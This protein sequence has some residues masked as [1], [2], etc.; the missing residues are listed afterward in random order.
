M[1]ATVSRRHC[2]ND[3]V[4]R[5]K[6]K[7]PRS[8]AARESSGLRSPRRIARSSST[9]SMPTPSS[10]IATLLDSPSHAKRMA[11]DRACAEMLLSTMS[12][13]AVPVQ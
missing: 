9:A 7:R 4:F 6:P 12:A 3:A 8:S 11:T 10:R 1:L 13:S 5:P 2:E